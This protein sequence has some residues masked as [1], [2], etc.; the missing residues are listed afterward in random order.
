MQPPSSVT[1]IRVEPPSFDLIG[2]LM[3]S[4]SLTGALA[5]LAVVLGTGFGILL[6]RRR[7]R[8]LSTHADGALSLH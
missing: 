1:W 5:A 8:P 2:V 3:S 7:S 6:I 4:L